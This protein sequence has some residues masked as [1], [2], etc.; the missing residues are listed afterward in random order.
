DAD[1]FRRPA[2]GG[3]RLLGPRPAWPG[4]RSQLP[5]R[6]LRVRPLRLRCS[7]RPDGAR[8]ERRLPEP[9]GADHR[10]M[11]RDG[12]PV[13]AHGVGQHDDGRAGAGEWL[14]PAVAPPRPAAP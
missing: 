3:P 7:A 6:T 11:R 9:S 13:E 14:V 4:A 8:L 5:D 12:A 1:G 10:R 2:Y